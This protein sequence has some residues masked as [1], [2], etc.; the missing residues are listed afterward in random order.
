MKKSVSVLAPVIAKMI[1]ISF[2]TGIFPDKLKI[3]KVTPI[4]KGGKED[5]ITNYRPISIL[6]C[7]SKIYERVMY[8]RLVEFLDHNQ[9]LT[10]EQFGFRKNY[11]PKLALTK[12]FDLILNNLG[13]NKFAISVFLD[14]K[15]AFDTL[16]H[17]IL[18]QKLNYYGIRGKY[19]DW[20]SSYLRNRLQCTVLQNVTSNYVN[21]TTGVPQGSTLGPLL[22]LIYINDIIKCSELLNFTIFADDTNITYAD[23]NQDSLITTLNSELNKVSTWLLSNRLS[24]NI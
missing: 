7:F 5:N 6:P 22:F 13:N 15:K 8:N 4:Y 9:I 1:N 12:L 10:K 23:S 19:N 16:N 20:F 17:E 24:L 21:I 11:S 14:L 2:Q 3:A 18:I